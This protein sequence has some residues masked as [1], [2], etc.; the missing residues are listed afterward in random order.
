M[1]LWLL[2]LIFLRASFLS[3][4]GGGLLPILEADLVGAG[5][6]LSPRDFAGAVGIGTIAPGP[7]GFVA[8]AVGY[9]A[10]GLPGALAATLALM[11]PPLTVLG[12]RRVHHRYRDVTWVEAAGRG[13]ALASI[14]LLVAVGAGLWHA[15]P[16][17]PL[18]TGL[19]I[20]CLAALLTRRVP[21][22]ILLLAGAAAGCFLYR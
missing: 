4:S 9:F 19:L 10:R 12:V 16:R 13:V 18:D 1:S 2:F 7:Y 17:G 22:G 3:F 15:A 5:R 21:P 14:G 11:I 8:I 6:P 20:V